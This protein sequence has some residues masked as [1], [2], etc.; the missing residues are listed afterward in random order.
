MIAGRVIFDVLNAKIRIE[1]RGVETGRNGI[2][3][4]LLEGW[5]EDSWNG[6]RTPLSLDAHSRTSSL[7]NVEV[8][9]FSPLSFLGWRFV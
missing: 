6:T 4:A 2:T 7:G 9:M 5:V 1:K 8:S 3:D